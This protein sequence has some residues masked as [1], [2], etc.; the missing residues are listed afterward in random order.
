MESLSSHL[1][2]DG[3]I[4]DP[5]KLIIDIAM[6][7][8][9]S[10][11]LA[12]E[13][14]KLIGHFDIACQSKKTEDLLIPA[15]VNSSV[16]EQISALPEEEQIFLICCYGEKGFGEARRV[17]YR[18][19]SVD[20]TRFRQGK[21]KKVFSQVKVSMGRPTD[22]RESHIVCTTAAACLEPWKISPY[23]TG[24]ARYPAFRPAKVIFEEKADANSPQIRLFLS[25]MGI[26]EIDVAEPRLVALLRK[27]LPE[28]LSNSSRH[29][30]SRDEMPHTRDLCKQIV[31]GN[32]GKT[33]VT[34]KCAC[35]K[36]YYCDKNCQK[37]KWQDH[38]ADHKK[39]MSK[40]SNK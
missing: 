17:T 39:W 13:A 15:P 26:N 38:K 27:S 33:G 21:K 35:G 1:L 36:H 6:Q 22:T 12:E 9:Q 4:R 16:M 3:K 14:A 40:K 32:C 24:A 28:V 34:K 25:M 8:G 20:L 2:P 19:F 29:V 31:C 23:E 18:V 11:Q 37:A 10:R 30:F 5:R 7:T